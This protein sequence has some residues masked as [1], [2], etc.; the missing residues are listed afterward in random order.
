MDG[1]VSEEES[2]NS[3]DDDD[4]DDEDNEFVTKMEHTNSSPGMSALLLMIY[5]PWIVLYVYSLLPLFF[6]Q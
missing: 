5:F 2:M 6:E 1:N 4:D 3:S